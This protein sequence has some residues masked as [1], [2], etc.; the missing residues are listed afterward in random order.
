MPSAGD[1]YE[2]KLIQGDEKAFEH[3]FKLYY[4][5]LIRFAIRFL[6]DLQASEEIVSDVFT[7]LW[8][9][10]HEITF[11]GTLQSYLFKCIQNRCLNYVKRQK[12]H[13][14]YLD[15]LEKNNLLHE[16]FYTDEDA[17][18]EKDTARQIALAIESL[19]EKC[20]QVF[21]LSRY[22]Y[23]KYTDIALKLNISP[24][25]VERHMGIALEKLR[26]MLKNVI[27]LP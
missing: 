7:T 1:L 2:Y 26:R 14:F 13:S 17:L 6:N 9:K 12:L 16:A 27:Y 19:P 8:E 3:L 25:T 5:R 24:K 18:E 15:Y 23:L 4:P 10:G 21:M 20:R 22:E 11:T